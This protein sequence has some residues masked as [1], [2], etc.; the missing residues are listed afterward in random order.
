M[1][2]FIAFEDSDSDDFGVIVKKKDEDKKLY[3]V[4]PEIP[5]S[6]K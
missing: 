3:T 4:L 5:N 1:H 2:D 6:P